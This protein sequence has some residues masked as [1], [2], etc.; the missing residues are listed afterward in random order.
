MMTLTLCIAVDHK[1]N[2]LERCL[3]SIH[4]LVDEIIVADM[5]T[6]MPVNQ[7]YQDYGATVVDCRQSM[8]PADALN[9][10]LEQAT[11]DWIIWLNPNEYLKESALPRYRDLLYIAGADLIL[12]HVVE[13]QKTVEGRVRVVDYGHPQLFRRQAGFH[14]FG[15]D[16]VVFIDIDCTTSRDGQGQRIHMRSF[17]IHAE[18]QVEQTATERKIKRVEREMTAVQSHSPW[19]L[20]ELACEYLRIRDYKQ[21][22]KW[23]NKIIQLFLDQKTTPPAVIY[24]LKYAAVL[25]QTS[26]PQNERS[27]ELAA[28][29][30][31]DFT[32]LHYYIGL[33][34]VKQ[35]RFEEALQA[36]NHCLECGNTPSDYFVRQGLGSYMAHQYSG[37]C[38]EKLERTVE[39][40]CAYIRAIDSYQNY[41]PAV[42]ALNRLV[43]DFNIDVADC[44]SEDIELPLERLQDLLM[45]YDEKKGQSLVR[46]L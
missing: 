8:H 39:A 18:S 5:G 11:G 12:H 31:P 16:E 27:L 32:D 30:Y 14:F 26:F 42:E 35:S 7:L 24:K 28:R 4:S 38:L 3:Q 1:N 43:I 46:S 9:L 6:S 37:I 29:M 17:K 21:V 44:M 22:V 19:N 10:A 41:V 36:F 15:K 2:R 20:Y 25:D 33:N 13:F 45:A 23:T 34:Y 40:A